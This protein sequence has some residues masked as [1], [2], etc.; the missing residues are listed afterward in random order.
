LFK[1]INNILEKVTFRIAGTNLISFLNNEN[2]IMAKVIETFYHLKTE[3][4]YYKDDE[5]K[6][7]A[8][9]VKRLTNLGKL[10]KPKKKTS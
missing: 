5:F 9:E 2:N 6:G 7:A 4:K 3:K 1:T 8:K 10:E